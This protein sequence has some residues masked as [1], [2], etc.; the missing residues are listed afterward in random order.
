MQVR[1]VHKIIVENNNAGEY[2]IEK[3]CFENWL[4]RAFKIKL[5]LSGCTPILDV[6][7]SSTH[8]IQYKV[9]LTYLLVDTFVIIVTTIYLKWEKNYEMGKS[10]FIPWAINPNGSSYFCHIQFQHIKRSRIDKYLYKSPA[11]FQIKQIIGKK[12]S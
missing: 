3:F 9:V 12:Q 10:F 4:F 7:S 2:C 1:L 6:G 5:H 8:L 11:F